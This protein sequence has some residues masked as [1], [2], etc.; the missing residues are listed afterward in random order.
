[1]QYS[2]RRLPH[3]AIDPGLIIGY[4]RVDAGC[5]WFTTK[6]PERRNTHLRV[7]TLEFRMNDL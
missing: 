7:H 2:W 6:F 4:P 5:V 3:D 1:M